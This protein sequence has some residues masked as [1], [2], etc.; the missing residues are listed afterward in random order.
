MGLILGPGIFLGFVGSPTISVEALAS[1]YKCVCV[2]VSRI[3]GDCSD[4]WR[5]RV[6]V[7]CKAKC[8]R[9]LFC[10][11][12]CTGPCT[13]I[14][15][16]C[17]KYCGNCC[18][19]SS[20]RKKCG[21]P[22]NPCSKKCIWQC[23]HYI[24]TKLCGELCDRPRCNMPCTKLLQCRHPCVG[25]CGEK[26]P[27]VC[28]ECHKDRE[29]FA[30]FGT[31]DK[32]DARFVKLT[33]CGHVL[34]VKMMDQWMDQAETTP[35]GKPAVVQLKRCPKCKTPIRSSLRYG[36]V[37]KKILMDIEQIKQKILLE[38]GQRDQKV[39]RLT[40]KVQKIDRFVED[41][42]NINRLLRQRDL[43]DDHLNLI[44]NQISLLSFLQTLKANIDFFQTKDLP[45]GTKDD[46]ES[47]VEQLRKRVM[48]CRFRFSEQEL[49][50]LS[51]A[52]YRTQLFVDFRML[53][54][55]LDIRGIRLGVTDTVE[56][57]FVEEAL[58]SGKTIGKSRE[59]SEKKTGK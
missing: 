45:P 29:E 47:N 11:H 37:V 5:G 33:D 20:F 44:E 53:K 12:G 27:R 43:T 21:D 34:E 57:N 7:P 25:L 4:C 30:A 39:A 18:K 3:I 48:G 28:R 10:G 59:K 41:K 36:N 13:K 50:E 38:K 52:M 9:T 54:M 19:H 55:Q 26:C 17:T 2:F 8:D 24:C 32:A 49:E 56:I 40:L 15:P 22:C 51:E 16:P 31:E 42:N 46:L 35:D 58:D 23:Q 1:N 6:H 14:C